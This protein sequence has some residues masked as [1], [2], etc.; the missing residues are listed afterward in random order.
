[1]PVWARKRS[2]WADPDGRVHVQAATVRTLTWLALVLLATGGMLPAPMAGFV[3]LG[4]SGLCSLAPLLG[5]SG[6]LRM[7]GAVLVFATCAMMLTL[8]PEA[9]NEYQIYTARACQ[10]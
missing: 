9:Q 6:R 5:G 1:M 2:G 8:Y 7:I 3:L 10:P 4:L